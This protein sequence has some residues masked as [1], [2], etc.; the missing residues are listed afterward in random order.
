MDA[1]PGLGAM[2]TEL[3]TL[4]MARAIRIPGMVLIAEVIASLSFVYQSP[5][6]DRILCLV[7]E[8]KS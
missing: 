3:S 6:L 5:T 1:H 8:V 7:L 2:V 4:I